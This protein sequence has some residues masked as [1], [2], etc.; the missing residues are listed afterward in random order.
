MLEYDLV[1]LAIPMAWLM[2]EGLR[3][4]FRRSE[5]FALTAVFAAPVLFKLKS[6]D[7]AIKPFVIVAAAALFAV[8]L[9]RVT[10]GTPAVSGDSR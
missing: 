6:F 8:V 4:G 5:I 7:F 10:N 9:R 1:I 3:T 2:A